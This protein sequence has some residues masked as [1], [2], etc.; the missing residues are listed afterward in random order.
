[1]QCEV[2]RD[3][4]PL[5]VDEVCSRQTVELVR[6]HLKTCPDCAR[7][8]EGMGQKVHVERETA[9]QARKPFARL[10]RK[11][12]LRVAAAVLLTAAVCLMGDMVV[13]EV[14]A[15]HDLFFPQYTV[16]ERMEPGETADWQ[17]LEEPV[18]FD[19]VFYDRAVVN[20]ANS[21]AAVELRFLDDGGDVVLEVAVE[22]GT[23]A[24]L[25]LLERNQPYTVEARWTGGTVILNFI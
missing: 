21:E 17:Q 5:Y 15:V 7:F 10:R 25:G 6:E 11:Q 4:L 20:D 2:I 24:G 14:G 23:Q 12:F 22:P 3:L 19:S 13:Q 18:V 16:M 8:A 9:I 1:M